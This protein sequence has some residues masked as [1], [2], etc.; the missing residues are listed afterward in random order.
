MKLTL[1]VFTTFLALA[2]PSLAAA[3]LELVDPPNRYGQWTQKKAPC[4]EGNGARGDQFTVFEPG[5]TITVSWDEFIDHP[6]HF[7]V[8]FDADGQDDFVDPICLS[9][10]DTR[11]P[12]IEEYNNDAVLLDGITDKSGGVYEVEVELPDVTCDD[13]TLQVIQVMYDKPP[14]ELPGNDLYYNCAD[15][16]LRPGGQG[17]AAGSG[18]AGAGDVGTSG[19]AG[20]GDAGAAGAAEF[21]VERSSDDGSGGCV[22]AGS[23]ESPPPISA[24]ALLATIVVVARRGSWGG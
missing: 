8:A 13:C 16:E 9:G 18:D 6:G 4:G 20:A 17:D 3:H 7:R 21:T 23:G 5:Q 22:S 15:L 11:Q 2:T 24:L 12:T 10:C 14:Y 1:A 19:D